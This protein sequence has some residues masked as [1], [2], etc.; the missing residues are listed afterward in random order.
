MP[1]KHDPLHK[2]LLME[3]KKE[4]EVQEMIVTFAEKLEKK[5]LAEGKVEVK[6]EGK[7]EGKIEEIKANIRWIELEIKNDY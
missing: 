2:E 5:H 3:V 6:V 7:V 1:Q 4:P